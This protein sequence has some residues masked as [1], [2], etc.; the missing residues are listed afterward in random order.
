M[1][2]HTDTNGKKDL[3]FNE[4]TDETIWK[5]QQMGVKFIDRKNPVFSSG[6]VIPFPNRFGDTAK[7]SSETADSCQQTMS[8]PSSGE[9]QER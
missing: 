6:S 5:L 1:K 3:V 8:D 7:H 2:L 4:L 9:S